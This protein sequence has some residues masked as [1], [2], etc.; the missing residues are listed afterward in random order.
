MG[1]VRRL[2]AALLIVAVL[3]FAP[4]P[5]VHAQSAPAGHV[6]WQGWSFDYGVTDLAEGLAFT[7]V[8]YQGVSIL[9]KASFPVMRVFY[10]N[11]ACGPYADRLAVPLTPVSWANDA[12]VVHR[13]FTQNG[14]TWLESGL[15]SQCRRYYGRPY[16]YERPPV[17]HF[18]YPL[19]LLALRLRPGR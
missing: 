9:A 15:V 17:Q 11:D 8:F 19:S 16:F 5:P 1:V 3:V 18:S 4:L 10:E 7:D 13:T 14:Q 2:M 6:D 12:L